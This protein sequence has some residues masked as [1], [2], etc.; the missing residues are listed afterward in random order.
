[1][2]LLS[3]AVQQLQSTL[4]Q[5]YTASSVLELFHDG[6]VDSPTTTTSGGFQATATWGSGS[7][8]VSV[9]ADTG[10]L[11]TTQTYAASSILS[12]TITGSTTNSLRFSSQEFRRNGH[13]C[14]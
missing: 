7:A 10:S 11:Q 14:V 5:T 13:L 4:T 1:M 12:T 9:D 6:M 3:P 8:I 2:L